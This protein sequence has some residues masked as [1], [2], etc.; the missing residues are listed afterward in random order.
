MLVTG[1][2]ASGRMI[3]RHMMIVKLA[4]SSKVSNEWHILN[5]NKIILT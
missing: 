4:S 3:K 1:S 5:K 2:S